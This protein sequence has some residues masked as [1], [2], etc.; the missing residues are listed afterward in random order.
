MANAGAP[1]TMITIFL[2]LGIELLTISQSIVMIATAPA[3]APQ[4]ST[5]SHS[6]AKDGTS[7][8]VCRISFDLSHAEVIPMLLQIAVFHS[9]PTLL[10]CQCR[11][12]RVRPN[13]AF[14]AGSE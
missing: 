14:R 5:T 3:T 9:A 12:K 1:V 2:R 13:D 11:A 6:V 4:H 8:R 7:A 10:P